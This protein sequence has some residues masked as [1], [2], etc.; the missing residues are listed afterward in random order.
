MKIDSITPGASKAFRWLLIFIFAGFLTPAADSS[1]AVVVLDAVTSVD[2]AVWLTVVTKGLLLAEGG[3]RVDV[4]VDNQALGQILTGGDGYGYLKYTPQRPG[5]MRIVARSNS[6]TGSGLL[7]VTKP[8][9]KVLLIDLEGSFQ[10][11]LFSSSEKSEAKKAVEAL[12]KEFKIIYLSKLAGKRIASFWLE[13]EKFPESIVLRWPGAELL[14]S[15]HKKGLALYAIVGSPEIL[16]DSAKYVEHRFSFEK[17]DNGQ[18]V[19]D[20][21]ELTELLKAQKDA[22]DDRPAEQSA[23]PLHHSR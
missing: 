23:I 9:D 19:G 12:A 14:E 21:A 20:W 22:H 15:L 2:T 16:S 7:L 8:E 10:N 1:A 4:S 6:D 18:M 11:V 17:T 5:L 3:Q 13:E